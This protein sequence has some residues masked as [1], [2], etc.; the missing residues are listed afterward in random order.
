MRTCCDQ[1]IH[2]FIPVLGFFAKSKEAII[3]ILRIFVSSI[4]AI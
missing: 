4:L 3:A 2:F 1:L